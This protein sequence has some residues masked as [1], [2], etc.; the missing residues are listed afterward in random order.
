MVCNH[1]AQQLSP[2]EFEIDETYRFKDDT[3]SG[4]E[5][6]VFAISAKKH[7]IKGVIVNGYAVDVDAEIAKIVERLLNKSKKMPIKRNE[8]L[9][10]ISREHHHSL[11]LCWK[12]KTGLK[13][14]IGLE[15]IKKYVDW[16][17]QHH[18]VPHFEMEE[19]YL[20]VVL[21]EEHEMIKK[22]LSEHHELKRLCEAKDDLER[23][24][25]LIEEL[26]ESHIRFEE[27][28]LFNEIQAVA[29]PEQLQQIAIHHVEEKF[30]DNIS[31]PFWE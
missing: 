2:N 26:L 9:K 14:K 7:Q 22:A 30:E 21:G 10:P 28:V 12:I 13:K 6:I 8:L 17:Y 31:D 4:D 5:M 3:D 15:R 27:R 18:I 20:F 16:F 29:T 25:R 11:L 24:F 19:K 23:T 1:T